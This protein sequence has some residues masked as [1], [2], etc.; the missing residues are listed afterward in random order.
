MSNKVLA[1]LDSFKGVQGPVVTVVMD[2]VGLAPDTA[3]NAVK[4]AYT[5]NLDKLLA[6]FAYPEALPAAG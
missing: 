4:A 6:E 3:G 2:G 5:P 1:P